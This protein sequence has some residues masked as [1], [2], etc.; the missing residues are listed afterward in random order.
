MQSPLGQL[1]AKII[2]FVPLTPSFCGPLPPESGS[3]LK[4]RGRKFSSPLAVLAVLAIG[5]ATLGARSASA[6]PAKRGT[7]SG[8]VVFSD[9]FTGSKGSLPDQTKWADYSACTYGGSAAFG[10]IACGNNETLDGSGNLVIP[11]TPTSGSAI[12]TT[13]DHA[14]AYGVF[15]AWMKVPAQVGYWPAFW[16]L[17]NGYDGTNQ[18]VLGEVDVMEGYTTWPTLYHATAHNWTNDG[19]PSSSGA[20]N[21]CGGSANL[22]AAFHKY[23][24]KIEP[25]QI[26][27]YLDNVQCGAAFSPQTNGS[28][29]Y[30]FG[31]DV[32]RG[33]WMILDLAVGGAGGQQ[34]PATKSARLLVTRVEVRNLP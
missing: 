7:F 15:S 1:I 16:T 32:M 6:V 19:T 9:S 13:S 14:Y 30:G 34:Q 22:S 25:N 10:G 26:T 12:R 5:A 29:P 3:N 18:P 2:R 8:A 4:R 20:D 17:N 27:F 33:N 11:A 24:A 28:D 31:P 21:Y 23:S